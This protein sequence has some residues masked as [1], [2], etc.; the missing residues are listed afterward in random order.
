MGY[1]V[2]GYDVD[3]VVLGAAVMAGSPSGVGY[4]LAAWTRKTG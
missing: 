1:E 3:E 4:L 2:P